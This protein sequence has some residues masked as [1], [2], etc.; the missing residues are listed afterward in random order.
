MRG[1]RDS[2]WTDVNPGVTRRL[3]VAF[4]LPDNLRDVLLTLR[5]V[6]WIYLGDFERM[7]S[8]D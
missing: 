3:A 8:Q 2:I 1:G 7:P 5:D 6:K 4:D